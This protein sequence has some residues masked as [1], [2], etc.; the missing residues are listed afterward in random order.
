MKS[1]ISKELLQPAVFCAALGLAL[2]LLLAACGRA[3]EKSSV[4]TEPA[5]TSLSRET[6]EA[7]ATQESEEAHS[8]AQPTTAS[9][10]TTPNDETTSEGDES[11]TQPVPTSEVAG[12][13]TGMA[14]V[15]AVEWGERAPLPEANSE[16]AVAELDGLIY[17][18]GGYPSSRVTVSSVQQY[19]PAADSWT[20]VAPLPGPVNHAMAAAAQGKLYVI[21]GQSG[22]SGGGP[23]LDTVFEYDPAESTWSQRTSMPTARGGGAAAVIDGKIYVAGGRPP[24]GSDFAVYDPGSDAWT[25]LPDLPTAR[26]HLA[27]AAVD[28]RVYVVGGRFGAGFRSEMTNVLE[29]YD[30]A[31]NAWTAGPPMP[32]VRG[33]LNAVAAN[34]CLHVF[35][36]EGSGG[37]FAEH[38]LYDPAAGEW[39]TLEPMPIPVHGVTGAAFL[40]G[41]IYLP[42]GGTAVG[43]SSGSTLNQVVT[44]PMTC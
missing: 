41:L 38:Q 28:G 17:V 29:I 39:R 22:A 7:T 36:G 23:F 31:T 19:D 32:T 11:P 34:G 25:T 18:I 27:V 42:G 4:A 30:P 33:G 43:G 8:E 24:R 20:L 1:P 21:G 3:P 44:A 12:V 6:S 16:I 15:A 35:G 5:G 9:E 14:P 40:D 26:N 37:V 13:P 10:P 2:V